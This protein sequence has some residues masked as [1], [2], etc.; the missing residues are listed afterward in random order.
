[1]G[2]LFSDLSLV[3]E[4]YCGAREVSPIV[5]GFEKESMLFSKYRIL[6]TL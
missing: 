4:M 3:L 1:M 2:R 6:C 5:L